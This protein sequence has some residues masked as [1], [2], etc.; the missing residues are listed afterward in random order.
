MNDFI[1]KFLGER[2]Y[3]PSENKWDEIALRVSHI[4][5]PILEYILAMDFIPSSPTLMNFCLHNERLGTLSS[6]FPL[7]V[8]DSIEG[9]YG[10]IVEGAIVTKYGGGCGW[11]FSL[12]R[13]SKENIKTLNANSS[14][15]VSFI[16]SFNQML[17]DIRQGGK[18]RGAGMGMMDIR[19]PN[20][21]DF[22]ECK[23]DINKISRLNISVRIPNEFYAK[24]KQEPNSPHMVRN[25]TGDSTFELK[26]KDGKTVTTKQIWDRIVDLAW[27]SAEPGIFNCDI[28][29]ERC[30]VTNIDPHVLSNPCLRDDAY[31]LTFD[32]IKQLKDIV[33]GDKIWSEEEWTTVLKKWKTGTKEVYRYYTTGGTFEATANHEIV[34]NGEKIAVGIAE[35]ID[36]LVGNYI[37]YPLSKVD[38]DP[39]I[40]M[41]GLVLGD[42]SIHTASNNLIYLNIGD[43]DYDYF[44]SEIST[45]ILRDRT[46]A[47]KKGW[48]VRTSITVDELP[49]TYERSIP[50]RYKESTNIFET[51]SLLRGLYSANGSVCGGRVTYKTASFQMIQDIQLLLSYVGIRSY[52]TI[53][54]TK[55][56]LFRNGEYDC[57]QSYDLNITTDTNK[58]YESIGFIQL[59]KM[60]KVKNLLIKKRKHVP[61]TNY[62]IYKK[63]L[64]GT[65]DVYDITVDNNTHTFWC[66][67]FNISNC[68]EFTGI[69][70]QSCNLGSINLSNF[71]EG[72]KFNWDR[73]EKTIV[74]AT[75]FLN[76]VIDK[77]QYPLEKIK[78]MTF[79]T[80]PMGLG[81]MGLAHAMFK[82]ELPYN[83]DKAIKFTEEMNRYLT[84]R[85]M[86]ESVELAKEVN[87]KE[88]AY[89]GAYEAF[90]SDLFMKANKRFFTHKHCRNIDVEQLKEDII[91]YGVRNSSFTSIAP[92]GSISFIAE[93]SS[94][95][96]P[97][98]ALSYSR[99]IEKENKEYEIVYIADPVFEN[100]LNSNFDEAM[101]IKIL[102]E[103]SEA[104]G[105]CQKCSD[106][107]ED[108]RKVFITAGD[109]TPMEHLDIL[110]AAAMNT[111]LSVSKTINLTM[112]AKREDIS[113]VFI[114][115]HKR[116]V[117]GVTVYREGSRQGIL[118]H[119]TKDTTKVGITPTN[120]PKRPKSLPCHVYKITTLNK[121][122]KE[123]EKWVVFVGLLN[124]MPYEVF[125]GKVNMVD[126]SSHITEGIITKVSKGVYQLE[127]G[128]EVLIKDI[129][130]IFESG[131]E[132]A[133]TRLMSTA[134]RH[135]VDCN[136]LQEQLNKSY[137]SLADFNKAISKALKKYTKDRDLTDICPTCGA[138]L[139]S[140]AGC[141][142]CSDP[143]CGW[144]KCGQ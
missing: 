36:T 87:S 25:I 24:L 18:R 138:K 117:I 27:T 34:S 135:G 47:F 63:E 78:E 50:K 109:L 127:H 59:Y 139:R 121:E 90:N 129:R 86:K 3:L 68:S 21:L 128:G 7:K 60:D 114:E 94:G 29:T 71:V 93:C 16:N 74:H 123:A 89:Y 58:F 35:S 2:Y 39:S 46:K 75:R 20:I 126:I 48:E 37:P 70:Y 31:L 23:R 82:K 118:V 130:K 40:V 85:A 44:S 100:Y 12:L 5:P 107:P 49:K 41:D 84:L 98:F 101:K 6:C 67:G 104:K 99:K 102:K 79:K 112:D 136:F 115:A 4:Y 61:K 125:A 134:L 19:H 132:E 81:Y 72:K 51:L 73:F 111:S 33:K 38:K 141:I 83:S 52:Y 66:N 9:I 1:Q 26:D 96:E 69:A 103:V 143:L 124:D 113:D 17:E 11:D 64:I 56:V 144:E 28:A 53:N 10:A 120:S 131:T 106:M 55:K 140:E 54:K 57:K 91:K 43:N 95:I 32:G 13:S 45:L 8:E 92:T 97:I 30:T 62:T 105:S 137:G 80:R 116:G 42:G 14:G 108:M 142:K 77:N 110:E 119:D 65:E 22:I 133:L 15:P 76:N 122:T 88:F